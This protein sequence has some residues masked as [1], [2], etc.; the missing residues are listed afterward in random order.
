M[1]GTAG[2]Y[3]FEDYMPISEEFRWNGLYEMKI[4]SA[5]MFFS[6]VLQ[7]LL[8][9]KYRGF[10]TD[11]EKNRFVNKVFPTLVKVPV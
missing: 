6:K 5:K 7:G 3:I 10:A 1:C 9:E 11:T 4:K 2:S 8:C